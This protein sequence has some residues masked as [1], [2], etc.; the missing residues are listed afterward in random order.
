MSRG[1]GLEL[2][3]RAGRPV[4]AVRDESDVRSDPGSDQGS[5]PGSDQGSGLGSGL[6]AELRAAL[7]EW[8]RVADAV[9]PGAEDA[10]VVSRRGRQLAGRVAASTGRA[11]EYVDPLDGGMQVIAPEPTP[12]ATGL[13]VS[14]ATVTLVL[15]ALV[16]LAGSLAEIAPWVAVVALVVASAGLAPSVWLGRNTP[17]WRWVAY[18]VAAGVVASWVGL[19]VIL[20]G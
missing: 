8:A 18:G 13:T 19:V 20:L 15:V 12:W 10:S 2:T 1:A 16:S 9:A 14:A 5:D 7:S 17:V 6:P 11:V 3:A 4:L